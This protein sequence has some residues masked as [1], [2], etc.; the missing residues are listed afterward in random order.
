[1]SNTVPSEIERECKSVQVHSAASA[2]SHNPLAEL[3]A[4]LFDVTYE[5]ASQLGFGE[6]R[7]LLLNK[8]PLDMK[9]VA[10]YLFYIHEFYQQHIP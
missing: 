6:L 4:E 1:M 10:R 5:N 7:D 3:Y 2:S 9:H 8:A